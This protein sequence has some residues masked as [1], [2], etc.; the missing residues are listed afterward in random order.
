MIA[1]TISIMTHINA[2]H[3]F[4]LIIVLI[5]SFRS[6][7][8][9]IIPKN[10]ALEQGIHCFFR[11]NPLYLGAVLTQVLLHVI[12]QRVAPLGCLAAK[13]ALTHRLD[14]RLCIGARR[15]RRNRDIPCGRRHIAPARLCLLLCDQPIL[16]Q[17]LVDVGVCKVATDGAKRQI[18]PGKR[19]FIKKSDPLGIDRTKNV[20]Y[21]YN[22]RRHRTKS[23]YLF[24]ET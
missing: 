13:L 6:S 17:H 5:S 7:S 8:S 23:M 14:A 12:M 21:A 10:P 22:K 9:L 11:Q 1:V 2:V 3:L 4:Q 19:R 24:R 16:Y 18:F 15:I 20:A